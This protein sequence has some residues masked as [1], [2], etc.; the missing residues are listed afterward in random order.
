MGEGFGGGREMGV[1]MG[2][3]GHKLTAQLSLQN[4]QGLPSE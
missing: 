1:G 2:R 4:G 3:S